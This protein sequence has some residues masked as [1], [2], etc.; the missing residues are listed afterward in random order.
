MIV[1]EGIRIALWVLWNNKLRSLLTL[2]GNVVSVMSL[3]A[4][5]SVIDGV[6]KYVKE[7]LADKGTGVFE[8]QKFN[9]FDFLTDPDKFVEALKNPDL[10]LRDVDYLAENL[11]LAKAVGANV[12]A[13]ATVKAGRRQVEGVSIEGKSPKYEEIQPLNLDAGRQMLPFEMRARHAVAIIGHEV[14]DQLFPNMDPIGRTLKINGIPFEVV[15]LAEERG[16]ILGQSQDLF[17][18]IPVAT[19]QKVFGPRRWMSILVAANDLETFEQAKDEAVLAMRARHRLRP[20]QENNF[21]ITTSDELLGLWTNISAGLFMV[22]TM[23]VAVSSVV[24]GIVIMN[25]MLMAVTE[26]TREIGI[27]KAIG[28]RRSHIMWQFL[29]ESV[30]MAV[31]GGAIGVVGGFLLALA[32]KTYSP[33]PAEVRPWSIILGIGVTVVVGLFFGIFPARRAAKLDPIEALRYE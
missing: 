2:L 33:M 3:V 6:N 10:T 9:E 24:A 29:I 32:V 31:V 17:I 22:M 23:I 13:G 21:A 19:F 1:I 16:T 8:V 12:D 5:V 25:I 27:R 26:R 20:G 18:Y 28:A 15:G 4:V 14:R 7:K 11:T 30:T